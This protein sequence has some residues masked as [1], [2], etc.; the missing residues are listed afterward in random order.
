[1]TNPAPEPGELL[2]L[3]SGALLTAL[4]ADRVGN[5]AATLL[6]AEQAA[7]DL[8]AAVAVLRWRQPD[9]VAP[10]PAPSAPADPPAPTAAPEPEPQPEP[11]RSLGPDATPAA[12]SQPDPSHSTQPLAAED[13]ATA[14]A[15]IGALNPQQR[16]AFSDAFRKAFDVPREERS[17][18]NHITQER[19]L[20]FIR[21][22]VDEAEGVACP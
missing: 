14:Q 8:A 4:E 11:V 21:R 16:K 18:K 12:E 6:L 20:L 13:V 5:P 17:V 19:H 9:Q 10:A 2:S 15:M 3:A 7:G 1:M 22:F